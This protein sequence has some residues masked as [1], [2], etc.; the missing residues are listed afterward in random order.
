MVKIMD[1]L[2]DGRLAGETEIKF[3]I[4]STFVLRAK[5]I[6]WANSVPIANGPSV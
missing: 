5:R 3:G 6:L 1:Q 2:G 4:F